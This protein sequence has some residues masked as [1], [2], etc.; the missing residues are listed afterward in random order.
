MPQLPEGFRAALEAAYRDSGRPMPVLI[1]LE[2][3]PGGSI[4]QTFRL[5][6]ASG[7]RF[8]KWNPEAPAGLFRREAEGLAALAASGTSLILPKSE[9]LSPDTPGTP[10]LLVLEYL[11][12]DA[13]SPS[14]D[15]WER[16]GRGL[17]QLHRTGE[18]RFGF[19]RDNFCGL[20]LQENAWSDDWVAFYGQ[21]R[22][23]ALVDRLARRGDLPPD[24]RETYGKLLDRLP[25][26]L[27]HRPRPSLIHG[28]LWSG[29]FLATLRGP[30]LVDPACYCA[31]REAEWG[32]MLLFGGFPE[33]V[34]AAYQEA[35]PLPAGWRD[36]LPLY[37][38]YHVLNHFL[39]FGGSYGGQAIRIART[40][41]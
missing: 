21:K 6:T 3:V 20:T 11:E 40:F 32:M 19:D 41:I 26:L 18:M 24:H 27:A 4:N 30:A 35:W 14:P 29:N 2:P 39:L 16:L 1:S 15:T 25:A 17:A 22:L 33:R 9:A 7:V 13:D 36:R 8:C 34:L 10:S 28:D 23:G 12:P 31:D 38:L 37:Q 5:R